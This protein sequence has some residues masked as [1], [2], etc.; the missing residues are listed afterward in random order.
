MPINPININ[1][2]PNEKKCF[3][4]SNELILGHKN[5]II[6]CLYFHGKKS[7]FAFEK[8]II[9]KKYVNI[10]ITSKRIGAQDCLE[11]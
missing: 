2:M 10:K 7:F 1:L 6:N 11:L 3:S 4:R 5:V 9:T 8:S